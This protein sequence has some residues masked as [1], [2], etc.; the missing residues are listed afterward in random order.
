M[1]G[2]TD[3]QADRQTRQTGRQAGRQAGRQTSRQENSMGTIRYDSVADSQHPEELLE[4]S[5]AG[6]LLPSAPHHP[7]VIEV[8]AG[9][10][11]LRS[12]R[13]LHHRDAVPIP[14]PCR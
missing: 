6:L 8:E 14:A 2:R 7:G 13:I 3:R 5:R 10:L 12:F 9:L 1:E 4:D 11:P